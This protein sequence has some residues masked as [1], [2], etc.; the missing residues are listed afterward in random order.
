MQNRIFNIYLETTLFN[1]YF[2]TPLDRQRYTRELFRQV[3]EGGFIAYVSDYVIHEL[4]A[5]TAQEKKEKMLSLLKTH[6]VKKLSRGDEEE[7]MARIYLRE[8][9]F[10]VKHN[11]DALHTA[12]A[13]VNCLDAVVSCDY[14]HIVKLRTFFLVNAINI[15]EG[16]ANIQISR[17]EE[18]IYEERRA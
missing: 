8:E 18:V 17:P 9:I 14:K 11:F 10:P 5:E 12:S 4:L 1:A 3:K 16:Y 13:T 7:R 15:H 2:D 6:P